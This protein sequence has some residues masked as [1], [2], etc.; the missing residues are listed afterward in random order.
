[1]PVQSIGKLF[2]LGLSIF[3]FGSPTDAVAQARQS[4][5]AFETAIRDTSTSPYLVLITVVDDRTGQVSTGC[6]TANRLLGAIYLEKWGSFE[7]NDRSQATARHEEVKRIALENT[8]HTFHFSNQAALN[9]VLPLRFAE[10]CAAIE[11]GVH[12]KM[13][14]ITGQILFGPFVRAPG[15][16]RSGCSPPAYPK[17]SEGSTT[18]ALLIGEDGTLRESK[19][20][21]SSGSRHWDEAVLAALSACKF[22][23]RTIDGEPDPEPTW[24]TIMIGSRAR[25]N[26]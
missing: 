23:P 3:W 12:A 24:M 6:D 1:M 10:A 16:V 25:W 11:R 22:S 17:P 26:F 19:I 5:A 2:V 14:D 21:G 8:P 4:H 15:I 13:A 9:N 20:T 7:T 18:V